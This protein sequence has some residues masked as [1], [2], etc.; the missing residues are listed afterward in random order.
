MLHLIFVSTVKLPGKQ[1]DE[2]SSV[3]YLDGGIVRVYLSRY[4]VILFSHVRRDRV[5]WSCVIRCA[6]LVVYVK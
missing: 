2:A 3:P 1:G 4:S 5:V 6:L